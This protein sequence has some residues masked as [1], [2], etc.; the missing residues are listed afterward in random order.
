M[1]RVV[2]SIWSQIK[3][4]IHF[5]VS[6]GLRIVRHPDLTEKQWEALYQF[7]K[8]CFVGLSNTAISLGVYYIVIAVNENWYILGNILGFVI[9][10]L[11]SY[12]WNSKYVFGKTD[13]RKKT[14]LKTFVAYGSNLVLGSI[15]LYIFIEKC[16]ISAVIAPLLILL[17]TIP[18]N[19]FLNKYWV[20]R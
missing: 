1:N 6:I 19:F 17:I 11:N 8:F 3:T 15:L 5:F 9:S 2:R 10:V 14:V 16:S 20:M 12:Y 4:I 13:D 7:F 18:L